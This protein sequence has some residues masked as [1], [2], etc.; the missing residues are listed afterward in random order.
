MY[1][2]RVPEGGKEINMDLKQLEYFLVCAK[3]ASLTK[4]AE[5]LYT[6]QP[7]VS[8]VIRSLEK[9]LGVELFSR[10]SKGVELTEEGRRILGYAEH[11]W[12]D[13]ELIASVCREK[14]HPC[15]RI[16]TNSSSNMAGLLTAYY[17]KHADD[18]HLQYTECGI[19]Q[20]IAFISG[21]E[22]ELGFLFVPDHKQSA[23]LHM[24]ERKNLD[25]VPLRKVDMV[26]YAGRKN[27]LYGKKS[28]TPE[29][30]LKLQFI[31][32][33]DDFFSIEDMLYILPRFLGKKQELDRVIRTNSNHMMV[34]M[35]Q[36]TKLCNLGSYWLK[37]H[38]RQNDFGRIPVEGFEGRVSFGYV[39]HCARPLTVRAEGF[40]LFLETAIREDMQQEISDVK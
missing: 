37:N 38:Y 35:L 12:K 9:E 28:I 18:F 7:H 10:R 32:M 31:Q 17:Q 21:Q 20:M 39:K 26:L 5:E 25:F 14:A 15:L 2:G 24:L 23:L 36:E 8:M 29:E 3:H 6:T 16:A 30:L 33:E 1:S 34:Q 13:T 40:L 4:A 22:Y 19:E 27:P 11:A